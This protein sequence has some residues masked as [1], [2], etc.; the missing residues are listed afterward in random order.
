MGPL[1]SY[2]D[3]YVAGIGRDV[4]EKILQA[5]EMKK[6]QAQLIQA[7][8]MEAVGTLAGGVAHD[9][10]NLLQA[11]MGYIQ[12]LLMDKDSKHP[13]IEPLQAIKKTAQRGAELVQQLFAFSRKAETSPRPLNLNEEVLEAE[14]LLKRTIP[15]MIDIEL[16]LDE[17]LKLTNADPVQIGQVIMNL[18]I[19][20]RDAMP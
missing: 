3:P 18:A 12:I 4:T 1:Y 19:N 8:R 9:F 11:I 10:N 5:K 13:D 15:K 2:G 17:H 14:K 16:S 6:L 20:A 7:Q